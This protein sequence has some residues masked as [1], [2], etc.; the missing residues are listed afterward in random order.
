[1]PNP[2]VDALIARLEK[3][4]QKTTEIFTSLT[5]VQWRFSIYD[6]PTPWNMRDLLA[7]FV[8]SEEKLLLLAQDVA[9]GGEGAPTGFNFEAFNAE[10]QRRLITQSP[11]TLLTE[12]NHARQETLAWLRT[13]DESQLDRV[14]RHPVLG[15]VP[16][17]T[18]ITAIY[19]HQLLHMR[20][21]KN[22]L[23]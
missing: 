16:L 21:L 4:L 19:G 18:M 13:L 20:D 17:E 3:G 2:R 23:G 6:E 14:G 12:L 7:H 9:A 11:Q 10:E 15:E 1:M 22:C 8:S 5:D